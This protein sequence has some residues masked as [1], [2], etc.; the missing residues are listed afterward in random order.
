MSTTDVFK[1]L[2]FPEHVS[3]AAAPTLED[4]FASIT[5]KVDHL[6]SLMKRAT[7]STPRP[8][9][10]GASNATKAPASPTFKLVGVENFTHRPEKPIFRHKAHGPG[11]VEV[12]KVDASNA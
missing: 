7:P 8:T 3:K 9:R 5:A 1:G 4:L 2:I 12:Q 6:S 11:V 10:R